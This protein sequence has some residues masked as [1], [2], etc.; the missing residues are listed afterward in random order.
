[1]TWY[2]IIVGESKNKIFF[3]CAF[4]CLV[5]EFLLNDRGDLCVQIVH[6]YF[7]HMILYLIE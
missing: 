2:G 7:F 5:L 1:M 6:L 3:L 4:L